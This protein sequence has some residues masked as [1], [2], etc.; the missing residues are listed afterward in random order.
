M[1]GLCTIAIGLPLA[2]ATGSAGANGRS[3]AVFD[4]EFVDTSLEGALQAPRSDEQS[5]LA[6]LG[7]ELRARLT[8]SGHT[9]VVDIAPLAAQVRA[10]NL[11][12]CGG[13]D[14]RFAHELGAEFAIIGWVQKVSNLILNMNIAV[15]DAKTGRVIA[16]GSVDM[17]GNTDESW[18]RALDWLV[19]NR[20]LAPGQG[21]F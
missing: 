12:D 6:W 14:A 2:L 17:R 20:L 18:S 5:R 10:S 4:F 9:E 13:C 15:R 21:V 8:K 7:T 16:S 11:L 1:R 19:R 3:V